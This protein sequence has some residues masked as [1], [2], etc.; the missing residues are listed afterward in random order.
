MSLSMLLLGLS[1][2]TRPPQRRREALTGAVTAGAATG[3]VP[4]HL[5]PENTDWILLGALEMLHSKLVVPDRRVR[6]S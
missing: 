2:T 5:W 1:E 3:P 4:A 6:G